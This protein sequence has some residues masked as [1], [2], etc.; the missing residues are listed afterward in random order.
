MKL[1]LDFIL[2]STFYFA[3]YKLVFARMSFFQLNRVLLLL[4]PLISLLIPL[5]ALL[6][7]EVAINIVNPL[8]VVL[9]ELTVNATQSGESTW[10]SSTTFWWSLYLSVSAFGLGLL[11]Y[12]LQKIYRVLKHSVSHSAFGIDYYTSALA[13]SP[14]SFLRYIVLPSQSLDAQK[15]KA[16]LAHEQVHCKQGHTYD[17]LYVNVLIRLAWFNPILFLVAKELRQVHECL[18]DAEAIKN[19]S[20]AE[21]AQMLLSETFGTEVAL[22]ANPFF[23][24]SL[25]KTRITMMY[26]SKTNRKMKWSYL[27]LLPALA[28]GTLYSCSK[29]GESNAAEADV[30][31]QQVVDFSVVEQPPLPASCDENAAKKEQML[32]FQSAVMHQFSKHFKY[33]EQAEKLGIEGRVVMGF[34]VNTD[35]NIV[36]TE[37]ARG[38][39]VEGAAEEE[40]AQAIYDEAQ[41]AMSQVTDLKAAVFNGTPVSV[42]FKLPILLKLTDE[43]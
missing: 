36:D 43:G 1:I 19:T 9:P 28:L 24:S 22:P 6:F 39:E 33:P 8:E 41:K 7:P 21:Y 11:G 38:L 16:I 32:C 4:L 12:Q 25:I 37:I 15:K 35:G 23:N 18:A 17:N 31:Q 10:L 42:S 34:V 29:G 20:R 40:A 3:L 13:S 30:K 5:T 14:F 27:L 2:L 26:K